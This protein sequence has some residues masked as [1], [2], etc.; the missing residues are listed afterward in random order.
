MSKTKISVAIQGLASKQVPKVHNEV[1]YSN[2]ESQGY[3]ELGDNKDDLKTDKG[4][5]HHE[6]QDKQLLVVCIC[7]VKEWLQVCL[8]ECGTYW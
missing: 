8:P 2:Q 3:T 1:H 5:E 6:E 4:V 7:L